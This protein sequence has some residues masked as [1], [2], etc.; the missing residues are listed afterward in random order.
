[1]FLETPESDGSTKKETHWTSGLLLNDIV[2]QTRTGLGSDGC[3]FTVVLGVDKGDKEVVILHWVADLFKM[4][5][6]LKNAF[7][8]WM[9]RRNVDTWIVI[10]C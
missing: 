8:V 10:F 6:C 4:A 1:M 5:A 9:L 3:V 2:E 7:R